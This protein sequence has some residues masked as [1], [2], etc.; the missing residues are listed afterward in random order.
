MAFRDRSEELSR[1]LAEPFVSAR[2]PTSFLR[3]AIGATSTPVEPKTR[4]FGFATLA[5]LGVAEMSAPETQFKVAITKI[6]GY[7]IGA[8]TKQTTYFKL[9]FD[10]F[11]SHDTVAKNS[12]DPVWEDNVSFTYSTKFIQR[13]SV[14]EIVVEVWSKHTFSAD[15]LLGDGRIDLLTVFTGPK[16]VEIPIANKSHAEMGVVWLDVD[17]VQ[18]ANIQ[19]NVSNLVLELDDAGTASSVPVSVGL[20]LPAAMKASSTAT[21]VGGG[22]FAAAAEIVTPAVT[23][24]ANELFLNAVV[25][26]SIGNN[27]SQLSAWLPVHQFYR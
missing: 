19:A 1:V 2:L 21:A 11:K 18:V 15:K 22:A 20:S 12:S 3:D 5:I 14:K 27:G 4:Q 13:L 17:V 10:N 8:G 9:N 16:R 6:G 26:S 24:F 25:I 23:T 7:N